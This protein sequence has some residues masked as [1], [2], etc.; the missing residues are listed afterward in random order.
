M[1]HPLV[2]CTRCGNLHECQRLVGEPTAF[3]LVCHDC[4]AL[5][6]VAIENNLLARR[7]RDVFAENRLA[8]VGVAT[9]RGSWER[10][11]S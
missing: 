3:T 4:E 2:T 8:V 10:W 7:R 6:S 5:L 9:A 11:V 1:W